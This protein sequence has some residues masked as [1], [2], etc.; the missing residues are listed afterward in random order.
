MY[1]KIIVPLDLHNL[2]SSKKSLASAASIAKDHNAKVT[3]FGMYGSHDHDGSEFKGMLSTM[4]EDLAKEHNIEADSL[5]MF[6][7]DVAAELKETIEDEIQKGGFDLVV[8]ASHSP[9]VLEHFFTSNA[10]HVAMH[11]AA[12]VFVVRQ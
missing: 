8:M 4:A 5:P 1:S 9:G 11:S 2:E 10:G 7:V 12:S 3:L 6:S